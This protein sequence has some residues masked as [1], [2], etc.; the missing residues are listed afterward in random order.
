M[1]CVKAHVQKG[2]PAGPP[3]TLSGCS[4][5]TK[6][7]GDKETPAERYNAAEASSVPLR[8]QDC[9][10]YAVIHEHTINTCTDSHGGEG[11]G[12]AVPTN[13]DVWG[14]G[15][16]LPAH[17]PPVGLNLRLEPETLRP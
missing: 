4:S 1:I 7:N 6:A 13:T 5:N 3:S 17:V 12:S 11:G 14:S 2:A 16:L 8:G 10:I 9:F 15:P